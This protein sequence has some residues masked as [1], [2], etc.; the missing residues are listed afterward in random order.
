MDVCFVKVL[1]ISLLLYRLITQYLVYSIAFW[2]RTQFF[3]MKTCYRSKFYVSRKFFSLSSVLVTII[4]K[5]ILTGFIAKTVDAARS[6]E[7]LI[8]YGPGTQLHSQMVSEYP[9]LEPLTNFGQFLG[10]FWVRHFGPWL[11][12]RFRLLVEV[13]MKTR[14]AKYWYKVKLKSLEIGI[15]LLQLL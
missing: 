4:G 12:P 9:S 2:R 5:Q 6:V 8:K 14:S 7:S 15:L 1:A 10:N 11:L 3:C 13:K